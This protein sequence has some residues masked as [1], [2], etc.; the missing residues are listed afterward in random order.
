[1]N[2]QAPEDVRQLLHQ[3]LVRID[4]ICREI[5]PRV[6]E[7]AVLKEEALRLR[8]QLQDAKPTLSR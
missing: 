5:G 3:T 4:M 1:M 8:S 6:K 2:H 7:L